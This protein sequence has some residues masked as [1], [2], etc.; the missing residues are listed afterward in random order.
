M[1]VFSIYIN[2]TDGH[3]TACAND[4]DE[5][6]KLIMEDEDSPLFERDLSGVTVDIYEEDTLQTTHTEPTLINWMINE[7]VNF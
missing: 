4:Q 3:I 5:V 1:K 6:N 7:H 2:N